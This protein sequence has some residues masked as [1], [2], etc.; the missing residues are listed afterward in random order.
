MTYVLDRDFAGY[1][2]G[3]PLIDVTL[4]EARALE[5]NRCGGCCDG[6]RDGVRKDEATGLP[7]HTWGSRYPADL[8]AERYGQALLVPIVRGDGGPQP[9]DAFEVDADGRA[10]TCFRCARLVEHHDGAGEGPT[11]SCSLYGGDPTQ[12]ATVR[13]RACGDFPVFGHEVDAAILCGHAFVPPTGALPECTW[14]GLRVVGPWREEP[15]WRE[16]WE[17][18]QRGEPVEELASGEE[19]LPLVTALRAR[20]STDR[21]A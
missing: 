15:A 12:P 4:R 10:Y 3:T 5:C 13:P 8:Y 11:T 17:R 19:I 16:R 14:Y 9:G 2:A 1:D 6:T 20:S 7:L 18:Q 21:G